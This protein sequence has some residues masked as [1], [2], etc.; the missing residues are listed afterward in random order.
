MKLGDSGSSASNWVYF[1]KLD[2][3]LS[4]LPQQ[5][6]LSCGVDS[7]EYVFMNPKVYLNRSNGLDEMRDS[8]ENSASAG[9]G[10]M[11]LRAFHPEDKE[12]RS[13]GECSFF[14]IAR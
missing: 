5:A 14:Q 7:G 9:V 4:S 1:K 13:Q 10:K 6:G 3:L 12:W 2:A 11:N 8:P